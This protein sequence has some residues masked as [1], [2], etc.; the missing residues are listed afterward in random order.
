MYFI[1]RGYL[2]FDDQP[3][4]TKK[5]TKSKRSI[6]L[7]SFF[8]NLKKCILPS[9]CILISICSSI[10]FSYFYIKPKPNV[11]KSVVISYNYGRDKINLNTNVVIYKT[12]NKY[13]NLRNNCTK[14][15][16]F[17]ETTTLREAVR[18]G[19]K[20][21]DCLSENDFDYINDEEIY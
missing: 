4:P 18:K 11:E 15:N 5:Q 17:P 12:N 7:K 9:L 10:I 6:C 1:K 2:F 21:C 16:L 14:V 19:Y 20:P 3:I 13:H 8:K